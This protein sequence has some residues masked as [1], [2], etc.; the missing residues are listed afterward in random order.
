MPW[1]PLSIAILAEAVALTLPSDA[2]TTVHSLIL[3][4][5][6]CSCVHSDDGP[7]FRMRHTA[8]PKVRMADGLEVVQPPPEAISGQSQYYRT[9]TEMRRGS[10]SIWSGGGARKEDM[11]SSQAHFWLSAAIAALALAIIAAAVGLGVG[12]SQRDNNDFALTNAVG[13][14]Y[15]LTKCAR[16]RLTRHRTPL[17]QPP[18]AHLQTLRIHLAPAPSPAPRR[19]TLNSAP[20]PPA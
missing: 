15:I 10:R 4:L 19:T 17:P 1:G 18:P 12:L 20:T 7:F 14:S 6:F 16:T 13:M 2:E 9:R 8:P 3:N 5:I 11:W